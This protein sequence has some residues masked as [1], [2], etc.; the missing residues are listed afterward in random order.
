MVLTLTL[1]NL[2]LNMEGFENVL[3]TWRSL[4]PKHN[5]NAILFSLRNLKYNT[6][7]LRKV[8]VWVYGVN[9]S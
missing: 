3:V 6:V 4:L 5:F 7:F 2:N 9:K 8:T 1:L